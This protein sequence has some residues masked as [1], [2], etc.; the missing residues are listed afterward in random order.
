MVSSTSL[1]NMV[2]PRNSVEGVMDTRIA[3]MAFHLCALS[4][5]EKVTVDLQQRTSIHNI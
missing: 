1:G 4:I 2:E 5:Q 3:K